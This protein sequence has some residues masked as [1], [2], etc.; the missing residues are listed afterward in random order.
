MLDRVST[1]AKKAS[2]GHPPRQPAEIADLS[3]VKAFVDHAHHGEQPAGGQPVI[4]HLQHAALHAQLIQGEQAQHAETEVADAGIGHQPLDVALGQG[5][6]RAVEHAHQR[7]P[8]QPGHEQGGGLGQHRQAE[9]RET[10]SAYLQQHARQQDA[11]RRGRLD[12]G[13][14]QPGV[15]GKQWRLN[16]KTGKQRQE[17]PDLQRRRHGMYP[18]RLGQVGNRKRQRANRRVAGRVIIDPQ[19]DGQQPQ[20]VN[21]LPASV[22]TKNFMAA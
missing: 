18:Q 16:G 21:T 6:H 8:H 2:T 12:V 20:N 19:H 14:R 11:A 3:G 1:R 7:D 15:Q 13:Q 5:H 4:D 9:P 17:N 10:V 22:N